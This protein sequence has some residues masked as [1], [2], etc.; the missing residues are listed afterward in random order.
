MY[1]Y[2]SNN[3]II[4]LKIKLKRNFKFESFDFDE[5][6]NDLLNDYG[7]IV[8]LDVLLSSN[9]VSEFISNY[10]LI[11]EIAK[12]DRN[13]LDNIDRQKNEIE[14][15]RVTLSEKEKSLKTL[16]TNKENTSIALENA[17]VI[18]NSYAKQLTN[19]EKET[20]EKIAGY[21]KELDNLEKD[22]IF[23]CKTEH[24]G[25]YNKTSGGKS[26][27]KISEES[28]KKVSNSLKKFY[29]N[30]NE[31]E[32]EKRSKNISKGLNNFY[33]NESEEHRQKR[34][35][36]INNFFNNES[37][38]HKNQRIKKMHKHYDNESEE[39]KEGGGDDV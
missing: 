6:L 16:K 3:T 35:D 23:L 27:Y 18:K 21:Q 4:I 30:Q 36:S 37:K 32:K 12:Y 10:Y 15:I 5:K 26:N 22:Y 31:E 14:N 2:T 20:Q 34:I 1:Y 24:G 13:L 9:S 38:E 17:K 7:D 25:V 28:K 8:Y 11:G 33:A 39:E 29:E 19:E